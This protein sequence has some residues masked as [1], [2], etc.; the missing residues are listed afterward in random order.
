MLRVSGQ[1]HH[2]EAGP[3][4]RRRRCS[5]QDLGE[6]PTVTVASPPTICSFCVKTCDITSQG[7]TV[8]RR[9]CN[10]VRMD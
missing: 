4:T 10:A 2:Q 9:G 5:R 3:M 6:P 1:G 8:G 7:F